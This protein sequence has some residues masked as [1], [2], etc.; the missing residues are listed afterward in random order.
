MGCT[1]GAPNGCSPR[2][3]NGFFKDNPFEGLPFA[4][5]NWHEAILHY[6]LEVS[7]VI[8]IMLQRSA[9]TL[10]FAAE[11]TIHPYLAGWCN[12]FAL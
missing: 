3:S 12:L 2:P 6:A 4:C 1:G 10:S 7:Y 11:F 8:N 9:C 5:G